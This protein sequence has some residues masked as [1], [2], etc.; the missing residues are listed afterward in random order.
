MG[1]FRSYKLA[2]GEMA[3]QSIIITVRGLVRCPVVHKAAEDP[4]F[5]R[6]LVVDASGHEIFVDDL[7][8][9][10]SELAGILTRNARSHRWN[11]IE[12]EICHG[13]RAWRDVSFLK[14]S[15]PRRRV[16]PFPTRRSSPPI[17][18]VQASAP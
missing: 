15:R 14:I 11:R 16:H 7:L 10:K 6:K 13:S 18:T 2:A 17:A 4:V 12:R 1:L 5:V 3:N 8:P 9:G